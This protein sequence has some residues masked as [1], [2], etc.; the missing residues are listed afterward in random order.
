MTFRQGMMMLRT[1]CNACHGEGK[2]I[3][4]PCGTCMAT[5]IESKKVAEEISIP[6][7]VED[8]T[9]LKFRGKGHM[10]GDLN[11]KINVRKH[12]TIRRQGSDAHT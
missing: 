7:G 12:P 10:N 11:V 2:K 5:G 9:N 1:A 3:T 6:R 4:S 8:G